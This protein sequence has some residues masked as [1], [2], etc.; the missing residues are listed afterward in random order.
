M[1]SCRHTPFL[2]AEDEQLVRLI[3][4]YGAKRWSAVA[5]HL[6]HRTPK[7]CRER[8]HYHLNPDLNKGPWTPEEDTIL[9]AKHDE[10]GNH[11]T[12]IARFLPGRT[13][14][15]VKS[16]W[17]SN[18]RSQRRE[19]LSNSKLVLPPVWPMDFTTIP[20]LA[21]KGGSMKEG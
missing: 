18:L 11:W 21:A 5:A 13:D 2:P 19:K 16:R 10:L 7:Q 8:W 17:N 6:S 12:A 15:S 3:G 14:S 9:L 1:A 20:P 4:I